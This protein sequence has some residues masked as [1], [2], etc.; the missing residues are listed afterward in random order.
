MMSEPNLRI[1]LNF[2]LKSYVCLL[3]KHYKIISTK[4]CCAIIIKSNGKFLLANFRVSDSQ[5]YIYI[6][7]I[8]SF[9]L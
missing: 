2:N 9:F 4:L 8:K 3:R 7:I 1:Y 5:I 6:Y